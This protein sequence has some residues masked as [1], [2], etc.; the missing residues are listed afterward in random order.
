MLMMTLPFFLVSILGFT[1]FFFFFFFFF[2]V[3]APRLPSNTRGGGARS[4][5]RIAARLGGDGA[6]QLSALYDDV[7]RQLGGSV[8]TDTGAAFGAYDADAV[9][10]MLAS[11]AAAHAALAASMADLAARA[12]QGLGYHTADDAEATA[13]DLMRLGR[14]AQQAA[15]LDDELGASLGAASVKRRR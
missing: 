13:A 4:A 10:R 1:F 9:A 5:E 6:R 15:R 12:G 8:S 7:A 11:S 3:S 14:A 2:S